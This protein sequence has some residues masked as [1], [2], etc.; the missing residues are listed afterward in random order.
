MGLIHYCKT[1]TILPTSPTQQSEFT[2]AICSGVWH[3]I[4]I[5]DGLAM[6]TAV[7]LARYIATFSRFLLCKN[8]ILRGK[9]CSLDVVSCIDWSFHDSGQNTARVGRGA[10]DPALC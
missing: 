4:A 1:R 2:N 3:L 7:H 8:S 5:S 6:T 10:I 9:S